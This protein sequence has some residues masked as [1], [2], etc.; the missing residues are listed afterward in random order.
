MNRNRR[1][2]GEPGRRLAGFVADGGALREND[3]ASAEK[4]KGTV[5]IP[6]DFVCCLRFI[7]LEYPFAAGLPAA[8]FSK[9]A[10]HFRAAV[11]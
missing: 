11:V 5:S 9:K 10:C 7:L 3:T 2:G 1:P 6:I 4:R 8:V